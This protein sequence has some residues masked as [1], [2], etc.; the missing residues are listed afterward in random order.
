MSFPILIFFKGLEDVGN[1]SWM[2]SAKKI[3]IYMSL[4]D[5]FFT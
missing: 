1:S 2:L 3:Y 5:T 4:N